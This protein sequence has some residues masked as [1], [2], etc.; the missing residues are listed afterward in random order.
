MQNAKQQIV[1]ATR[2]PEKMGT[3][4]HFYWRAR[5]NLLSALPKDAYDQ[6]DFS[7]RLAGKQILFATRPETVSSILARPDTFGLSKLHRALLGPALG[8]GLVLSE[9]SAWQLQRRQTV[10]ALAGINK[11]EHRH[12]CLQASAAFANEKTAQ[13]IGEAQF[14]ALALLVLAKSLFGTNDT[15]LDGVAASVDAYLDATRKV[16]LGVLVALPTFFHRSPRQLT[17][18]AHMFD[19]H[20]EAGLKALGF[21]CD[22]ADQLAQRRDY[23]V[24]LLSGYKSISIT[25]F[26]LMHCLSLHED[27]L[28]EVCEEAR[29][30]PASSGE[31]FNPDQFQVLE[32]V[33]NEVL[34]L[35]PPLPVV[36]R[37]CKTKVEV[38]DQD[39]KAGTLVICGPWVRN[40]HRLLWDQ[41]DHF[42]PAR[43]NKHH[44]FGEGGRTCP[45]A[46]VG[47]QTIMTLAIGMLRH[48]RPVAQSKQFYPVGQFLARPPKGSTI[49]WQRHGLS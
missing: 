16:R 42:N 10:R 32:S 39:L 38:A 47:K 2:A 31:D 22:Q 48:G 34:R 21:A 26:W 40:R 9:G 11:T 46:Q 27:L 41:P 33:V 7:V 12:M 24:N 44:S 1:F 18:L 8:Q 23:V 4:L 45:A 36:L 14:G 5:R 15:Q 43:D 3:P 29:Q 20:V 49:R 6:H 35:F 25:L 13:P 30:A 17:D 37:E 28:A 19:H